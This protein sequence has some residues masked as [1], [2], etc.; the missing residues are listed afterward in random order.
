MTQR[1]E[2]KVAFING[3][4]TGIGAATATRVAQDGAVVVL[5]GRRLEP[6]QLV[7]Q[8]I[9]A[10]G[11][12]AEA[13]SLDASEEQALTRAINETAKKYGHLDI[14]VNNAYSMVGASIVDSSTEDWRANFTVSLDATFFGIRAA[15]PLIGRQGGAI[16]NLSSVCGQLGAPYTAGYGAAKAGV[17]SLTRTAALEGAPM[18]VRVNAVVPGVVLTPGSEA[19]LPTEE[20]QNATAAGVPLRRLGDPREVANTILFLASDEASYI[21]GVALN[22]DGGKTCELSTG[23][24][25]DAFDAT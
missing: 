11:G 20:A 23:A 16:V 8:E 7:V 24:N 10:A 5:C 25:M 2:N 17:L 9:S 1:L 14:L 4:G 18:N 3:A 15:L 12:R 22:V 21:T 19:V 13:F 6:L